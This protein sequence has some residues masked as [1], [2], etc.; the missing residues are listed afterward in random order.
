[1]DLSRR[2][3]L[4]IAA[5][6]ATLLFTLGGFDQLKMPALPMP[7]DAAAS[8]EEIAERLRDRLDDEVFESFLPDLTFA[9]FAMSLDTPLLHWCWPEQKQGIEARLPPEGVPAYTGELH[10]PEVADPLEVRFWITS[11]DQASRLVAA[12]RRGAEE[13]GRRPREGDAISDVADFDRWGWHGVRVLVT[14][15]SWT[16]Y[17]DSGARVTIVAARGALLAEVSWAWAFEAGGRPGQS[18]LLQGTEAAAS[19]LAAVGGAPSAPAP[20]GVTSRATSTMMA[21]ALPPPSVYGKDMRPWPDPVGLL[22]DLVCPS[23]F[24]ENVH[25]GAPAITRRLIGEVSI[26]EDVLFLADEQSAE[27]ARIRPILR[28]RWGVS[29]GKGV[30]PCDSDDALSY[31]IDRRLEPFT[32]GSWT[33]E[34]EAFAVRRPGSQ[35]RPARHDSVA[36]IAVAVRHGSTMVYL[37]WQG[38]AGA[39]PAAALRRGRAALTD[40]LDLLPRAGN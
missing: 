1:M 13:C 37:R 17:G 36:H 9:P 2:P 20:A 35:R 40:T 27:Q 33:G 29:T 12:T 3:G 19:V 4:R 34:I 6:A 18:P 7:A 16:E 30:K 14:T 38:P 21:A 11:P 15:E 10:A 28:A 39:A 31:S 5:A 32:R 24:D 23:G 22:H 8:A 25:G 26:R